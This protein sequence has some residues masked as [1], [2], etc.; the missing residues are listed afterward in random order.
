MGVRKTF[1]T[2]AV[3]LAIGGG[4]LVTSANLAVADTRAALSTQ[5]LSGVRQSIVDNANR[6]IGTTAAQCGKYS[7]NCP[8]Q[9]WCAHFTNWVWRQSGAQQYP[10]TP[11]ARGVGLWG[12]QRGLFKPRA[13]G[14]TPGDIVVFGTPGST[15]GGHVAIVTAV[16]ADGFITTVNGNYGGTHSTN[17]KV[18]AT[19]INPNTARS[20]AQNLPI[21]GYVSPPGEESSVDVGP[22]TT[23]SKATYQANT[24]TTEVFAR[25]SGKEMTHVWN[26]GG[27]WS[28]WEAHQPDYQ[29]ATNPVSLYL[30]DTKTTEAFAR[31]NSG[32]LVHTWHEPGKGW[33]NWETIHGQKI[34]GEPV[35]VYNT[36]SR[37]PEVFARNGNNELV[38]TWH[39]YG[40]GWAAWETIG[41]WQ[42]A[43][44]PVAVYEPGTKT[45]E[46]FARGSQ[47]ELMHTWHHL[48]SG[49]ADWESVNGGDKITGQPSVVYEAS[50][51]TV[52]VFARNTNNQLVHTWHA[53]GEGWSAYE[54]LG[55]WRLASD[56][57]GVYDPTTQTTEVF[58]R[59]ESGA[60]IHLWHARGQGW[61]PWETLNPG[62]KF[63]G[64]PVPVYQPHIR[65]VEVF[66][67]GE[68]G[69]QLHTWH[70]YG[71]GWSDWSAIGDWT[72]AE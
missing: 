69:R 18:V 49:W 35:A 56:P 63:T 50:T 28:A 67:R 26:S 7:P 48:G 8:A 65:T 19:R 14:A 5:A 71:K 27:K 37:T 62:T 57:A 33:T 70:P 22:A 52:E 10:N 20:G 54:T 30:E 31:N 68:D 43:G 45:T 42:L 1:T 38:H 17:S 23:S 9:D 12:Q 51:K 21:S 13:Q 34:V 55:D 66:A 44:D 6:E 16:H 61:S 39:E 29:L 59:G 46:V 3:L 60:L 11:V 41:N 36:H 15:P 2:L 72:I 4:G 40:K 32:E 24:K 25:G 64:V 58:A 53:P 47:G